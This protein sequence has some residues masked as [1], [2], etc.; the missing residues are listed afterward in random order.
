[1][2]L[3]ELLFEE[4]IPEFIDFMGQKRPTRNSLGDYIGNSIEAI[5]NFYK[6]FGNSKVVD[7]EGKPLVV[8]HG[9]KTQ[10]DK[11]DINKIGTV[12]DTGSYG[13]GFYFTRDYNLA[14]I[15]IEQNGIIYNVYLNIKNPLVFNTE[16]DIPIIKMV[17]DA[18]DK[19]YSNNFSKYVKNK[20]YDGIIS[21]LDT[22][23]LFVIYYPN[24]IKSVNNKGTFNLNIDNINEG[25]TGT[26]Y[27]ISLQNRLKYAKSYRDKNK[28]EALHNY[29]EETQREWLGG[30]NPPKDGFLIIYKA[31][32]L[33]KENVIYPGDY[34]TNSYEY[35][36]Q[37][38]KNNLNNSGKILKVKAHLSELYPADDYKEFF[39]YPRDDAKYSN[40]ITESSNNTEFQQILNDILDDNNLEYLNGN[41]NMFDLYLDSFKS[42]L[43]DEEYDEFGYYSKDEIFSMPEFLNFV[44]Q[45]LTNE[46]KEKINK[47]LSKFKNN[48][49][50]IYREITVPK[51]WR[52][53]SKNLGVYW[54]WDE[55]A[56]EAFWGENGKG[57]KNYLLVGEVDES[58]INW[59]E[60]IMKN[61]NPVLENECEIEVKQNAS[62]KLLKVINRDT[63]KQVNIDKY[64]NKELKA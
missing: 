15:F 34:V 57:Y 5:Q 44:K 19:E 48:K 47:I 60:T 58:N 1:M 8:Y 17:N 43:S 53:D 40:T 36:K 61:I 22:Q 52:P 30:V 23:P 32:P 20:G 25:H 59:D 54:S 16:N 64:I 10:F 31:I 11:F 50:V 62:I 51:S 14:K 35:A 29:K 12:T 24:Q 2:R 4:N 45:Q 18:I 46:Y 55:N 27:N 49:I 37:H 33:R 39:Y 41:Y 38:I 63:D 6:W 3:S 7:N 56:A 42:S 9:S 13:S 21:K 26:P 28:E